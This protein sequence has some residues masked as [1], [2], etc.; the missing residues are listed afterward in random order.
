MYKL[1]LKLWSINKNYVKEAIRLYENNFYNY[2]ELFAVPDSYNKYI[3]IWKDLDIP[4]IIHAPHSMCG[5]NL[6]KKNSWEQNYRLIKET[7]RF[8]DTLNSKIIIFHPGISGKTQEVVLQLNKINDPRIVV[9]NKPYYTLDKTAICN[10]YSTREIEFILKNANVGFCFDIAHAIYSANT[11]KIGVFEYLLEFNNLQPKIYHL[12]DGDF[13]GIKDEHE[14]LGEGSFD[15]AGILKFLSKGC[16]ITLE[17]KKN[18]KDSLKDFEKDVDFWINL[19]NK[20]D[21]K[22]HSNSNNK[23]LEC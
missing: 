13:R 4:Y 3:N 18:Y 21:K 23:V 14:H 10:G 7:L 5:L 8:A 12:A 2:I 11:Q 6:A 20:Y 22:E 17:T 1:G 15:F 9:E 19:E 16:M